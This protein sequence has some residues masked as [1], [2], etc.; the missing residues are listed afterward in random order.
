MTTIAYSDA[1]D[2]VSI[3][4]HNGE[5]ERGRGERDD[6]CV[7]NEFARDSAEHPLAERDEQN[8][9]GH[10]DHADH[11]VADGEVQQEH[12]DPL[13]TQRR[14]ARDDRYQRDVADQSQQHQH[15]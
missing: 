9:G 4:A 7:D 6:L 8:L 5:E 11:Q 14:L 3:Y 1:T 13:S 12:A 15:G 10:G 2:L